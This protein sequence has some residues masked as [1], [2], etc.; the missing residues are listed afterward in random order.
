MTVACGNG[1]RH[2]TLD[3]TKEMAIIRVAESE[4]AVRVRACTPNLK[5]RSSR[6]HSHGMGPTA[7]YR[8]TTRGNL[9]RRAVS[10][11]ARC[12]GKLSCTR[13]AATGGG[14]DAKCHGCN[15][16]IRVLLLRKKRYETRCESV[17]VI[18]KAERT[19]TSTSKCVESARKRHDHRVTRATRKQR[20]VRGQ[21][22]NTRWPRVQR[23]RI[24][25]TRLAVRIRAPSVHS[26]ILA[27]SKAMCS[28]RTCCAH[29]AM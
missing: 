16:R 22:W 11:R 12:G 25:Q 28:T 21:G 24:R 10:A 2:N 23:A 6:N 19:V 29:R 14:G 17:L 8:Y 4:L 5:A 1:K 3:T 7:G 20:N 18:A 27:Q 26:A 15:L 9:R 13:A